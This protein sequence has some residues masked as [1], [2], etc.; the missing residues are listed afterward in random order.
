MQWENMRRIAFAFL[1]FSV[2]AYADDLS[3]TSGELMDVSYF[4]G[5]T[6][7]PLC[8]YGQYHDPDGNCINNDYQS[9]QC[10]DIETK[11][12]HM[13]PTSLTQMSVLSCITK[14]LATVAARI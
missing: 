5:T 7:G 8:P 6:W 1:L 14:R 4:R 2:T 12:Q 10:P 3:D 13:Q 11:T 9:P